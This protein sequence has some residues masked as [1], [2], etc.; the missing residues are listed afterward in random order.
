MRCWTCVETLYRRRCWS[1][2]DLV[3]ASC[4]LPTTVLAVRLRPEFAEGPQRV[5]ST[6]SAPAHFRAQAQSHFFNLLAPQDCE[7]SLEHCMFTLNTDFR[8]K[9]GCLSQSDTSSIACRMSF[10]YYTDNP[11]DMTEHTRRQSGHSRQLRIH[12]G[13]SHFHMNNVDDSLAARAG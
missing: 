6:H 1:A 5:N 10:A 4:A 9:Q 2:G 7:F 13:S 11:T 3:W 8:L 12:F